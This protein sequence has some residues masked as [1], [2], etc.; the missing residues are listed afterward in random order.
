VHRYHV[1]RK[2]LGFDQ[3]AALQL[4]AQERQCFLLSRD[5]RF[6]QRDES[7]DTVAICTVEQRHKW[8]GTLLHNKLKV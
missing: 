4:C 6:M 3:A 8:Q 5:S 7:P 2:G 1:S